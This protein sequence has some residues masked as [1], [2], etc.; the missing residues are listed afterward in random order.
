M[1]KNLFLNLSVADLERSVGFFKSLGFE[2]NSDFTDE[3]AACMIVNDVTYVM[4]LMPEF[5]AGFTKKPVSDAKTVTEGIYAVS[6]DTR[7]EVDR[8]VDLAVALG[9]RE[10]R[11]PEDLGFMYTRSF[12]D[13]DGHEWEF[14]YMDP[15][16][17]PKKST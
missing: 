16:Y 4:L 12:E 7:S 1:P 3:K 15:D 5:F 6:Y 2:F 11:D 17:T 13:F 14:F 8:L 9:A 10:Y